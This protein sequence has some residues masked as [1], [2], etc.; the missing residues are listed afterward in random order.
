MSVVMIK[1]NS[2]YISWTW[3]SAVILCMAVCLV[4]ASGCQSSVK[5]LKTEIMLVQKQSGQV[6]KT[7]NVLVIVSPDKPPNHALSAL[8]DP[9]CYYLATCRF[10]TVIITE[11]QVTLHHKGVI[12]SYSL[13]ARSYY[14]VLDWSW[15][16][17]LYWANRFLPGGRDLLVQH[18]TGSGWVSGEQVIVADLQLNQIEAEKPGKVPS[19][20]Y[21]ELLQKY[22]AFSQEEYEVWLRREPAKHFNPPEL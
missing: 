2:K 4:F 14:Y 7:A 1:A 15:F 20:H 18:F 6:D 22:G 10:V 5:R 16:G 13:P 9:K 17:G 11:K 19:K 12:K 8:N 21:P 3:I